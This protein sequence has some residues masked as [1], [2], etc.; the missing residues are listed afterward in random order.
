MRAFITTSR[1]IDMMKNC[2]I[3]GCDKKT[4]GQKNIPLI[5][6]IQIKGIIQIT[7]DGLAY[8]NRMQIKEKTLKK[9]L[10]YAE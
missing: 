2:S 10:L 9:A 4:A 3:E 8:L 7:V 6:L 5:E 1:V